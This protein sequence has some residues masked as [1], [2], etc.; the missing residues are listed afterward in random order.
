VRAAGNEPEL[1][2]LNALGLLLLPLLSFLGGF[3]PFQPILSCKTP[4][5]I[6]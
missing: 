2:K 5:Q 1:S 4:V 6:A 3:A